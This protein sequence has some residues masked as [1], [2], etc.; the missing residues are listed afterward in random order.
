MGNSTFT[1]KRFAI[2]RGA[3]IFG[4]QVRDPERYG[5]VEFD[6]EWEGDQPR[7]KTEATKEPLRG[8]GALCL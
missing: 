7:G 1:G 2:E 3:C 5:V 6:A 8:A 4:Y